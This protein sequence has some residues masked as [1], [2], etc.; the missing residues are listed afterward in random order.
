MY[1]VGGGTP[2]PETPAPYS[3]GATPNLLPY[4][5]HAYS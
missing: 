4:Y 2:A 3:T 5:P 1:S